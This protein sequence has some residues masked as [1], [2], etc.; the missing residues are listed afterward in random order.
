MSVQIMQG[1]TNTGKMN[2]RESMVRRAGCEDVNSNR[3]RYGMMCYC[4]ILRVMVIVVIA[5]LSDRD[6]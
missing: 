1:T 2:R 4:M 5:T 6:G 3:V